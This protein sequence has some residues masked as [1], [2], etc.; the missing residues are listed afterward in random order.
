M[1]G[2]DG[3]E[4]SE[5]VGEF[6]RAGFRVS[7]LGPQRVGVAVSGVQYSRRNNY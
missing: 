2:T 4:D 3:T 7:R 6:L 5:E 1:G